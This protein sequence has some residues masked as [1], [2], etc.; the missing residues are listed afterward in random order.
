MAESV[1]VT[2]GAG[3]IGS[4]TCKALAL[5][6]FQPVVFDNLS[7]GHGYAVKW[8]PFIQADL[9]NRAELDKAFATYQPKAVIHFAADAIVT[10]SMLNPGKYYRNNVGSTIS[11]LEAMRDHGVKKLVFSSTCATYGNAIFNPITE[12]HPVHPINPYGRSKWMNEE[13]I[14]DFEKAHGLEAVILRYFNA[15]GADLDT[16]IGEDHTPETHLIP[17]IIQAALGMREEIVVYGTDFPSKDGSAVRD[18][19]HV[20]DLAAAHVAALNAPPNTLNLGTG[21]GASVLELIQAVERFCARP[22]SVR[23]ENRR[24]GEPGVLT[25]DFT[26]AKELLGWSPQFSDLPTIIE[27]AWKWH[28]LLHEHAHLVKSVLKC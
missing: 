3:Y 19:V 4:H 24:E 21:K 6:G 7:T 10:E 22:I 13:I 26:K 25:A 9:N 11:L 14:H 2:G 18:Y 20:M 23:L 28:Q 27:S 15:A 1:F 8:G 16:Q 5:A 12:K 17:T